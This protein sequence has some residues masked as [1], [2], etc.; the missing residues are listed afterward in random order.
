MAPNISITVTM[1][2]TNNANAA[3]TIAGTRRWI[4]AS[5]I[6]PAAHS[7]PAAGQAPGANANALDAQNPVNQIIR[8]QARTEKWLGSRC[9]KGANVAKL[10]DSTSTPITRPGPPSTPPST[11]APAAKNSLE[12]GDSKTHSCCQ[13]ASPVTAAAA[14]IRKK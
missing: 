2:T 5:T 7:P 12:A 11:V 1:N 13:T 8:S 9:T 6:T 4:A 3:S 10:S 14:A